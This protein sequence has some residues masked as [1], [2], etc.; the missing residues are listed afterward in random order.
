[1]TWCGMRLG[2]PI[3]A[4]IAAWS[5]RAHGSVLVAPTAAELRAELGR[6]QTKIRSWLIEYDARMIHPAAVNGSYVH[7]RMAAKVPDRSYQWGGHGASDLP[8]QEDPFQQ[9]LTVHGASA[10]SEHPFNREFLVITFQL[11]QGL[12]GTAGNDII[13][14]ALGWWGLDQIPSPKWGDA[15]AA[16]AEVAREPAYSVVR[17]DL[18]DGRDCYVLE[19]PGHDRIW[20]DAER[21][22]S[23]LRRE[24]IDPLSGTPSVIIRATGHHDVGSGIWA[25]LNITLTRLLLP[26]NPSPGGAQMFESRIQL[27]VVQVNEAV[28]DSLFEFRPLPG[29]LSFNASVGNGTVTPGGADYLDHLVEWVRRYANVSRAQSASSVWIEEAAECA[30][31]LVGL[32]AMLAK[33]RRRRIHPPAQLGV[34]GVVLRPVGATG[35]GF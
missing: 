19:R 18:M 17:R 32:G 12:P 22:Y 21:N 8:W 16:L 27:G 34:P 25:P 10:V 7:R 26:A 14:P 9:R 6:T 29:S 11:Q 35:T 2:V 4:I 23:I 20:V 31:I 28:P 33:H 13:F 5:V 3:A 15:P 24:S 30:V 1:M